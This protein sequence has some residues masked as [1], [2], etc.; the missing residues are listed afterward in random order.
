MNY[1]AHAN[2]CAKMVVAKIFCNPN[3]QMSKRSLLTFNYSVA[4]NKE[5]LNEITD[6]FQIM[7]ATQQFLTKKTVENYPPCSKRFTDG[8]VHVSYITKPFQD[9]HD[10]DH[11][12]KYKA[13]MT[14]YVNLCMRIKMKRLLVHLPGTPSEMSNLANGMNILA[15]FFNKIP[16]ITIVLEIPSFRGSMKMDVFEYFNAIITNY[17]P[18]FTHENV[19]LCY[20]TA[21]LFA[22][23]LDSK[24]IV[25][26]LEKKVGGKKLIDY[27]TVIHLN[28]NKQPMWKPD[29]HCP[30]FSSKNRMSDIEVLVKYLADKNKILIAEN[31]KEH[32][33]WKEWQ[34]FANNHSINIVQENDHA[35]I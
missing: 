5:W 12:N 22:N 9:L 13:L 4:G 35:S 27:C 3:R 19:E 23:G 2:E 21:H 16:S 6:P 7:P 15:K 1:E 29:A 20:D 33:S 18:L 17:F 11:F 14:A 28:G 8:V 31:T 30:I 34:D 24:D 10:T 26:L 25:E 32:A